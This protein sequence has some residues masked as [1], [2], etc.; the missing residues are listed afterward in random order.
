MPNLMV[1]NFFRTVRLVN[2]DASAYIGISG[3]RPG[4]EKQMSQYCR[5]ALWRPANP[6][7]P[8][9]PSRKDPA[10]AGGKVMLTLSLR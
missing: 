9:K 8:E 1:K 10:L 6:G 4:Q 3:K 5:E 2:A 7:L